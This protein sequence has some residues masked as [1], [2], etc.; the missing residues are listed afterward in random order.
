MGRSTAI[1]LL[2]AFVCL[3]VVAAVSFTLL[4]SRIVG[5]LPPSSTASTPALTTLPLPE[6][7]S[8]AASGPAASWQPHPTSS[9]LLKELAY[10]HFTIGYDE[11]ARN[12]AWVVYRLDGGIAHH[13]HEH[14]PAVFATEFR[15]AA[16]V[17]HHDYSGSG[18]DRGHMCPAYAMFSRFGEDGMQETFVM[19]NVIPQY[20]DLNAGEW[21]HLESAISGRDGHGDGWAGSAGPLWIINGPVYQ[22]RPAARQLRNRTWV[23]SSCFSVVLRWR[24]GRWD[25]LAV[26][27]PNREQVAG[28]WSRYLTTIGTIERETRLDLLAGCP[29]QEQER[30]EREHAS[31]EEWR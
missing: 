11:Q 7:A 4:G 22:S 17:S 1:I 13:G 5:E 28:P 29:A 6:T 10:R 27:M 14:R 12:P 15:T 19:S 2:I 9:L 20:H 16:Q 26:E 24:S 3:A 30:L 23:P 25:A 31:M 8:A 18:F 21:E